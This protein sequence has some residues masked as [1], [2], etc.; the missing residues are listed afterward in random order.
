MKSIL[1]VTF[2]FISF[3]CDSQ[4]TNFTF[5]K[6]TN[7]ANKWIDI[8]PSGWKL[9][10]SVYCDFDKDSLTDLVMVISTCV[11]ILPKDT[12]C[13][14]SE[15]FYPKM[16]IIMFKKPDNTFELSISATRFF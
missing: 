1:L 11:P 10:D 12:D 2:Y 3:S 8:I 6:I 9:V 16:L 7:H 14:S 15:P 13:I 4:V 5:P